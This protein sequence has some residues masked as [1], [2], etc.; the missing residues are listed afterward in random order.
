MVRDYPSSKIDFSVVPD[1]ERDPVVAWQHRWYLLLAVGTNMGLPMLFGWMVGDFWGVFLLAGVFRLVINHHVTFFI[2]SLAHMWGKQPYTDEN[3][4]RDN[5]LLAMITYGEGYH[6]YHHM[7]QSDYRN[8]HRWWHF[9]MNKWFIS[10]CAGL[11]LAENLTRTPQFKI[12]RAKLNMEFK[13]ARARFEDAE[14]SPGWREQLEQEYAEFMETVRQW[15]HLQMEKVQQGRQK[16][17]ERI[18]KHAITARYRELERSL[19][20]QHKRVVLL[21]AQ[22]SL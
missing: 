8:G 2:N 10:T 11:G 19:K 16:L 20:M 22:V 7:F 15:Q 21:A 14:V 17:A 4:A 6:N 18:E 5:W 3:S 12:L 13:T 9:D 1:L